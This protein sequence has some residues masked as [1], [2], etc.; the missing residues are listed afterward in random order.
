MIVLPPQVNAVITD[1]EQAGLEAYFVGGAVANYVC[2][3]LQ[4]LTIESSTFTPL[5][6]TMPEAILYHKLNDKGWNLWYS[7]VR[8]QEQ[9]LCRK[10]RESWRTSLPLSSIWANGSRL[11]S[12]VRNIAL[13]KH[14]HIEISRS[15]WLDWFPDPTSGIIL[16][17]YG[18]RLSWIW[19]KRLFHAQSWAAYQ[20]GGVQWWTFQR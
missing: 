5:W 2:D 1:L 15:V 3:C 9:L 16:S 8:N 18:S 13:A 4:L 12:R 17:D 11:S 14:A 20:R 7:T 6:W 19:D 10:E